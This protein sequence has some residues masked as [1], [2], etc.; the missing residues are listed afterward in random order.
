M[1]FFIVFAIATAVFAVF[2]AAQLN[3]QSFQGNQAGGVGPNGPPDLGIN[4]DRRG[5]DGDDQK[6][7]GL[8]AGQGNFPGSFG[9]GRFGN[10]GN[11]NRFGCHD[12]RRY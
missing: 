10:R 4:N 3:P 1:K 7:I 2:A 8:A 6:G 5:Q 9:Q 12:G 11:Q